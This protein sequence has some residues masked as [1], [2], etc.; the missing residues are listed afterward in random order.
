MIIFY[1]FYPWFT[2]VSFFL[3]IM[4]MESGAQP[5][6]QNLKPVHLLMTMGR[7]KKVN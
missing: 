7:K 1:T 5:E 3:S 4:G 2:C 6:E